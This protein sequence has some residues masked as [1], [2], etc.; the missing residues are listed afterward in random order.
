VTAASTQTA[1][2][3]HKRHEIVDPDELR[4][5]I[6]GTTMQI[7]RL[8]STDAVSRLEQFQDAAGWGLDVADLRFKLR[9]EGPMVPACIALVLVRKAN[10]TSVCGMPL[11]DGMLMAIPAGT[12][13]EGGVMPGFSYAGIT[14]PVRQWL[15]AQLVETGTTTEP[16]ADR[17]VAQRLPAG[18]FA[19]IERSLDHA[20]ADLRTVASGGEAAAG[21]SAAGSSA[22]VG[23]YL[24]SLAGAYAECVTEA[25]TGLRAA[26]NHLRDVRRA[27]GW[28]HAH[29]DEEIR[30][31]QLCEALGTSRRRLEYAFRR[32]LDVSPQAFITA[33]RL[34]KVREALKARGAKD[35]SVTQIAFDH[36]ITHLGRFAASYRRLFG[37]L[38]SQTQNSGRRVT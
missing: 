19:E 11:E 13:L 32:T 34:N 20:I 37:E 21:S 9:V 1:S 4:Y 36:G 33:L 30:I 12:T 2:L 10:G 24:A 17:I 23:R 26:H 5:A 18:R 35:L 14:V 6:S 28:I 29:I 7:D 8:S 31:T 25:R 22:I 27:Q 16:F 38:P 3:L 15:A